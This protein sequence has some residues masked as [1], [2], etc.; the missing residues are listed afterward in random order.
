[1]NKNN[2]WLN[3][4]YVLLENPDEI[5]PTRNMS[6][7]TR[8]NVLTRFVILLSLI[9]YTFNFSQ[10]KI[11][12]LFS[13][14]IIIILYYLQINTM[15]DTI[16]EKFQSR[17]NVSRNAEY[18]KKA[19]FSCIQKRDT[20]FLPQQNLDIPNSRI[21]VR[22][23]TL[24]GTANPKTLQ[25]PVI[26]AP[27]SDISYWK[28]NDTVT[29]SSINTPGTEDLYR[30]GYISVS[31][32]KVSSENPLHEF[33]NQHREHPDFQN[34]CEN[35]EYKR[36]GS[37]R[38]KKRYLNPNTGV[39]KSCGY[40]ENNLKYNIPVNKFNNGKIQQHDTFSEY[41][42]NMYTHTVMPGTYVKSTH[43]DP[44]QSNLGISYIG[45]RRHLEPQGD[46]FV[47]SETSVI[48]PLEPCSSGVDPSDVYD[49][50]HTGYG[51]SYRSYVD[52]KLGQPKFYYDDI[53][54]ARMPNYITRSKVDFI[55]GCDTYGQQKDSAQNIRKVV[56]QNYLDG[57][58][59]QRHDIQNNFMRKYKDRFMQLREMPL[60]SG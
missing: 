42:D 47:E 4:I 13:I 35:F 1:M 58:M 48:E 22:N 55:D 19:D 26:V 41:N 44:I 49:P 10:W 33:Q 36:R 20:V 25:Q 60:R 12:L 17:P 21:S 52:K 23:K 30:S 6:L 8:M 51:T 3:D 5:I 34:I 43:S 31:H 57:V 24:S 27:P 45:K 28:K 53:N 32:D 16:I 59:K 38:Y 7:A 29:H 54:S 50:R 14:M 2:F 46:V 15:N 40:D 37:K 39:H 9:L 18:K 56:H 11:F